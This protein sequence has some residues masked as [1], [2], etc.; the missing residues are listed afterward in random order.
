VP[1]VSSSNEARGIAHGR[2]TMDVD[3]H[4]L[5][6]SYIST[7]CGP[8]TIATQARRILSHARIR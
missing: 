2:Q 3:D 5:Y 4:A 8:V 7:Q 6:G 1:G